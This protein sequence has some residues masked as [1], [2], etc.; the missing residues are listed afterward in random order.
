MPARGDLET[1]HGILG[2]IQKAIGEPVFL[3]ASQGFYRE[4]SPI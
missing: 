1:E 3:C 2:E 4:I